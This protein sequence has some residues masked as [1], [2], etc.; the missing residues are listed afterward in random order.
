MGETLRLGGARAHAIWVPSVLRRR[1]GDPPGAR[2]LTEQGRAISDVAKM[3][4]E[5]LA[6]AG[7]EPAVAMQN[8]IQSMRP[9]AVDPVNVAEV[10]SLEDVARVG[11]PDGPLR[12]VL[13]AVAAFD[14]G[15]VEQALFR[16]MGYGSLP[17]N[18]VID[19]VLIPVL[20][21]IGDEWEAGRLSVAAEHF[22]SAII[23]R[24]LVQMI[25][26][27]LS[28][29]HGGAP[30]VC[31]CPAG[32]E[33]EGALLSFAV[34]AAREGL[35]VIYLG[36]NTPLADIVDVATRQ[37]APLIAL[38]V[39]RG[40]RGDA[41]WESLLKPFRCWV[42]AKPGRMTIWG[43]NGAN[44]AREQIEQAGMMVADHVKVPL[45]GWP[46]FGSKA[47]AKT[48]SDAG[49]VYLDISGLPAKWLG[50]GDTA[51]GLRP[52]TRERTGHQRR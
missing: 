45:G 28:H 42:E 26:R 12:D 18:E 34:H 22:G 41:Q 43:G 20:R 13:A 7:V 47:S 44:R 35:S 33:H 32:E 36:P 48:L 11:V 39:V 37:R 27:D 9:G 49:P 21:R 29:G 38:S 24:K 2:V 19:R 16:A 25:E 17:Q 8:S 15:G 23:R 46:G 50:V 1:R 30:V 31:A 40:P 14:A 4:R 10:T 6:T 3:P 5:E 51:Q 52:P